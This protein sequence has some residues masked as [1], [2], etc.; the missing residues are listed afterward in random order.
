MLLKR[1]YEF[2][3]RL[4]RRQTGAIL[5]LAILASLIGIAVV[6]PTAVLVGTAALRQG[7]FEDK[8]REFYSVDSAV[9]A[10]ISDL[11]RGADGFPVVPL[12]YIPPTVKFCDDEGENC[13]VPNITVRSLEAELA[14]A[15]AQG[16]ALG[17]EPPSLTVATTR[18]VN[19]KAGGVPANLVNATDPGVL[20]LLTDLADHDGIY[21]RVTAIDVSS[22][23]SYE[24]TSEVIGFS[25]V[26]FGKVNLVVRGWEESTF[27]DVFVFNPDAHGPDGY[28]AIPDAATLLDH[29]HALD[30]ELPDNHKHDDDHE[31]EAHTHDE[32]I[33]EDDVDDL[34]FHGKGSQEH[35]HKDHHA[36]NP[37][38]D[39]EAHFDEHQHHG[40]HDD[41]DHEDDEL[42]G[43][44][45]NHSH[46]HHH[47][48]NKD[49]DH[50]H[51]PDHL[52]NDDHLLVH[53]HPDD[54]PHHGHKGQHHHGEETISFSLDGSDLDYLNTLIG[55]EKALKIKVVVT[56][57]ADPDHHHHVKNHDAFD[58]D[59][60]ITGGDH[61]HIHHEHRSNPPPF[62]IETDQV[63]F[64][65]GGNATV[66]QRHAKITEEPFIKFGTVV[67]GEANDLRLDDVEYLTIKSQRLAQAIAVDDWGDEAND[68]DDEKKGFNHVVEFEVT[69]A[70]FVFSR[71]DTISIPLVLR[72]NHDKKAKIRMFVFNDSDH[73]PG[74][75]SIVPDL[76]AEVR[77][78]NN[79]RA[80]A[81]TVSD[82]DLVY[83]NSLFKEGV[84]N[85][86]V[87]V[88][89]RVSLNS[90]FEV[91]VDN[92]SFIATSTDDQ[93]QVVRQGIHEYVDPGLR[94]PAMK[95]IEHKNGYMLRVNSFQPG[96]MNINWAFAP[97][98]HA[99]GENHKIHHH[100]DE[101]RDIS[102]EVYRGLVV[103]SPPSGQQ[104]KV[105]EEGRT[106]INPDQMTRE[107]DPRDN[108]L[109]ARAHV[110]PHHGDSS[111]STGFFE[112]D[113]G[114]YT[115]I[116]WN[117][118]MD[119]SGGGDPKFTV[120]SN[121]FVAPGDDGSDFS[122][123]TGIYASVYRDYVIHAESGQIR[124]K[125]V[126]RQVPG[127]TENSF[128]G[129]ATD[130]IA[131]SKNLVLIQ[132]W[133]EPGDLSP[134]IV[135]LDEDGILDAVDGQFVDGEFVDESTVVS[136]N[137]TDQH[138]G[139]VTSGEI[140]NRAGI[141]LHVRDLND[142]NEGLLIWATGSGAGKAAV[143][144]DV[145]G[146]L[147]TFT[148]G[149]V[150]KAECGSTVLSVIQGPV[151][152]RLSEVFT[153]TIPG[154]A[155]AKITEVTPTVFG[156]ENLPGS[157]AIVV[158]E[159]DGISVN[160]EAGSSVTVQDG[161][162]P[163][164][165]G[166]TVTPTPTPTPGPTYTPLPTVTPTPLPT[167]DVTPTPTA[168][169]TPTPIPAPTATPTPTPGPT[170][171]PT[172]VPA[173]TPTP[174]PTPMPAP[175]VIAT[176]NWELGSFSG[177]SGWLNSWSVEGGNDAMVTS[178][179]GPFEGTFHLRLRSSDGLVRRDVNL[180]GKTGVHLTFYAKVE[181]FEGSDSAIAKVSSD[182][183]NWATVKTWSSADSD[184]VY[185]L[186]DIDLSGFT[187]SDQFF[188]AFEGNM[189]NP[190][191]RLLIDNIEVK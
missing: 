63:Q 31:K 32:V 191:D 118:D 177:G 109:V 170:P 136:N 88:K 116:Y 81:L 146:S 90:E 55:D 139:G 119:H 20:G 187:M 45:G 143:I 34:H 22:P 153:A 7:D 114:V 117:D 13:T 182:G 78:P 100:H 138:L 103:G 29:H 157:K 120:V 27:F 75:Y 48:Q 71:I 115:I 189:N 17:L 179:N 147:L 50:H 53:S 3:G 181:G 93:D 122:N 168:T 24:I 178:Q 5:P 172:T 155:T 85:I 105:G 161:L 110:H 36:L 132:S 66:D 101:T 108:T 160:L 35:G 129:W 67:S 171:T 30:D 68:D 61:D 16:A 52:L 166:P 174:T 125:A 14:L 21:Y 137:F 163:P 92:L 183:T 15:G 123:S 76:V 107:I 128:G 142:P 82:E 111:V 44:H 4:I 33:N 69:S 186:V 184:R 9:L 54:H 39:H 124:L 18:I 190:S 156:I 159:G 131:W 89:I 38:D 65:M 173:P 133:G 165:P 64:V 10:V 28:G 58:A 12:D 95:V 135:D 180:S 99:S 106:L 154:G 175:V 25:D 56:V 112:V 8:T 126:V 141:D 74:G 26:Q 23:L 2:L 134:V 47:D 77:A 46:D 79:D 59:G 87:K 121:P 43:H 148:V 73:G 162:P 152:V 140:K 72:M 158:V 40:H 62:S 19:F 167:P 57:F 6:I 1:Y 97:H 164:T 151:E 49:A 98:V 113:T 86:S 91:A 37:D 102:I 42:H 84:R 11:Q 169:A 104:A 145:C 80:Y 70:D 127:P 150:T 51:Y 94:N 83:L 41:N 130:N 60:K 96:V 185:E 188:I 149:A 144:L 176:E